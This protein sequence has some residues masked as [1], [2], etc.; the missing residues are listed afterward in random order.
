MEWLIYAFMRVFFSTAYDVTTKISLIKSNSLTSSAFHIS[1][2]SP[3]ILLPLIFIDGSWISIFYNMF[4]IAVLGNAFCN[5]IGYL[6][7]LNIIKKYDISYVSA[8]MATSPLMYGLF[9]LIRLLILFLF[10]V[11]VLLQLVEY[12]LK[13]VEKI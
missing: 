5:S 9:S 6:I 8:I 7:V 13:L 12:L 4:L 1:V 2:I 11:F 10:F 3:V